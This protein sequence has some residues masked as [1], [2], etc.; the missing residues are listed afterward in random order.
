MSVKKHVSLCLEIGWS[1]D[2]KLFLFDLLVYLLKEEKN[3]GDLYP[4]Y[5]LVA[6]QEK[7]WAME[8]NSCITSQND[9]KTYGCSCRSR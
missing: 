7:E 2:H 9:L 1:H 5:P 3:A 6:L 8:R 4:L